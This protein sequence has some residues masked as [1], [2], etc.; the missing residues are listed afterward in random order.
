MNADKDKWFRNAGRLDFNGV[1]FFIGAPG[2]R[3]RL[4]VQVLWRPD[5]LEGTLRFSLRH[6]KINVGLVVN[7][8]ESDFVSPDWC[9][10]FDIV[11]NGQ[12][13]PRPCLSSEYT[14]IISRNIDIPEE[15]VVVFGKSEEKGCFYNGQ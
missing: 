14:K 9:S 10:M 2:G 11:F 8:I 1:R 6:A 3:T 15:L 7:V 5:S 12:Y 13:G 4:E